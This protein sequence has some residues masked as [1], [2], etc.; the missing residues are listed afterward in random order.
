MEHYKNL[1]EEKKLKDII[2]KENKINFKE[3]ES[4]EDDINENEEKL[5]EVKNENENEEYNLEIPV[6]QINNFLKDHKDI[7]FLGKLLLP[8]LNLS[9][10]EENQ[11]EKVTISLGKKIK[12]STRNK[13][14]NK[15][16]SINLLENESSLQK[17]ITSDYLIDSKD[18]NDD[19]SEQRIN[20]K[21]NSS[22]IKEEEKS[23]DNNKE[24]NIND[25][26]FK[27]SACKLIKDSIY[28][29]FYLIYIKLK[30]IVNPFR[31]I[32]NNDDG[33]FYI[34]QWD[35]WG[36]LIFTVIL[37][38]I[39]KNIS[40]FM[41]FWFAGFFIYL[42]GYFLGI[43]Y[44]VFHILCLLGYCLFPLDV[45]A[46]LLSLF[47]PDM[48]ARFVFSCLTCFW[49]IYSIFNFLR[50]IY[51]E[52]KLLVIYPFALFYIFIAWSILFSKK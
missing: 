30:N 38:C 40:I 15:K 7:A 31:K 1:D 5:E 27:I 32:N 16:E 8:N 18:D 9:P 29:D 41:I 43:K 39:L 26:Q 34:I 4:K 36:P 42:N 44:N 23:N 25:L 17:I 28:R 45:G 20:I 21:E 48:K 13:N 3:K 2:S 22:K 46:I 6:R 10:N 50:N 35:L 19:L 51:P 52:Q 24:N 37:T 49:S 47:D 11:D 12:I 14:T 33:S